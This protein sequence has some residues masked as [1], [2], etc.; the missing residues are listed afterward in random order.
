MVLLSLFNSDLYIPP[1]GGGFAGSDE[2]DEVGLAFDFAGSLH[3]AEGGLTADVVEVGAS[4]GDKV[5]IPRVL[6]C[7][8]VFKVG[9]AGVVGFCAVDV[10][11]E[12]LHTVVAA[13]RV[14]VN[15]Q[16]A[17]R[18]KKLQLL[19]P[20]HPLDLRVGK[21]PR[22]IKSVNEEICTPIGH[23]NAEEYVQPD[24]PS[25]GKR[26]LV[27]RE[28]EAQTLFVRKAFIYIY[29]AIK[30]M[31]GDENAAIPH[32]FVELERLSDTRLCARTD[33]K[34]MKMCFVKVCVFIHI[35]V[36]L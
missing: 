14:G 19:Y 6:L 35:A 12:K 3:A 28:I 9:A 13:E 29:I 33:R 25:D 7:H 15:D 16:C 36:F 32:R 5:I 30:E 17:F 8:G 34:R 23:F 26:R 1:E 2:G 18:G 27:V 24:F 21:I 20:I 31:I 10:L 4:E 11:W 22:F